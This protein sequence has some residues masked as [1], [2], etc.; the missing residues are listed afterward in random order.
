M[1]RRNKHERQRKASSGEM[2]KERKTLNIYIGISA[3]CSRSS[4]SFSV[5]LSVFFHDLHDSAK[6]C[7]MNVFFFL[8]QSMST[9]AVQTLVIIN[10]Y[11]SSA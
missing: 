4:I 7:L 10:I 2:L 1:E 11:A 5:S 6:K 3:C 8:A 9:R